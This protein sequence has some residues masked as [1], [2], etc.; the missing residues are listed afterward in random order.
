MKHLKKQSLLGAIFILGGFN[1]ALGQSFLE[2]KVVG[3][4]NRSEEKLE[5][6]TLFWLGTSTGTISKDKGKFS[7]ER[8][9]G[10]DQL[11]ARYGDFVDTLQV[12]EN[13]DFLEVRLDITPLKNVEMGDVVIEDRVKP[14][15]FSKLD[16]KGVELIRQGEFRKAACCNLSESFETNPSV[17]A[18]FT[19]AV[20]G[21]RQIKMLGLS[22]KYVAIT[23][24]NMPLM[25]GLASVSGLSHIP[26][27]WVNSLQLSK[28]TGSVVNG[29]EGIAGQ[30]NVDH[31]LPDAEEVFILNGYG[32]IGGRL[33]GNAV[34]NAKINEIVGTNIM[35]H[36]AN[37]SRLNDRNG[38]G[39]LDMPLRKDLAVLNRWKFHGLRGVVGQINL[40]ANRMRNQSGQTNYYSEDL[41]AAI[42]YYNFENAT[43]HYQVYAKMGYLSPKDPLRSI[44]SQWMILHHDEN[45]IFGSRR[46]NS[47]QNALY[48]NVIAQFPLSGEKHTLKTGLSAR[49]DD[50]RE[51]IR[52]NNMDSSNFDRREQ[53]SGIFAEYTFEPS[54]K[55]TLV[56]GIRGDIHN[57]Y[58]TFMTPRLH[59]RYALTPT[60]SLRLSAGRGQRSPNVLTDQMGL[61]A[62]SRVWSFSSNT[63]G[64]PGYGLLPEIGWNMGGSI[65]Q[66]FTLD[67]REGYVRADFFR[68]QFTQQVII[69]RET[70]GELAVYPLEG[71]SFANSFLIEANYELTRRLDLRLAYRFYNV[72]TKYRSGLLLEPFNPRHRGFANIAFKTRKKGFSFDYTFQYIGPQRIPG[73]TEAAPSFTMMN[74]QINKEIGKT[75]EIYLGG[76]NLL[77]YRQDDPIIAAQD[78]FGSDF[79][80]TMVWGPVFGRN[81]YAGFRLKLKRKN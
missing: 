55:M 76:E 47:R 59:F 79:D 31:Y 29:F 50:F 21:A 19:D 32:N 36:A 69:D 51:D 74:A 48:G 64:L 24:E 12:A 58:G 18:S 27:T 41:V 22:G 39:F 25:S 81:V 62:S 70:P 54:P 3:I 56:A 45:A 77:D 75:M 38:D 5:G 37:V 2:G 57:Y 52:W 53:V 13:L 9:A 46:I 15:G 11:V 26:S 30:I 63:P 80:A 65:T 66:D 4:E 8:V 33:E 67:Y 20:T 17:D 44:G 34:Y 10:K 71:I 7:L 14:S 1:L 40:Q 68:T 78:P 49:F 60:T 42:P 6:A 43:D 72:Q 61:L 35:V 73:E 28:G 16:P 23:S